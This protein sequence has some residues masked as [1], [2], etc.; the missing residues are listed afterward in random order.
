MI[1]LTIM[2]VVLLCFL[3][4]LMKRNADVLRWQIQ[5]VDYICER[6]KGVLQS[7]LEEYN[8]RPSYEEMNNSIFS[9]NKM[10]MYFWL[11]PEKMIEDKQMYE[12]TKSL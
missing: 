6:R 10:M 2:F 3:V 9:Y 5:W 12:L 7:S 8:K 1:G 11:R 4:Y